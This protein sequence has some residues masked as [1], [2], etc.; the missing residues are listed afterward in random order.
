MGLGIVETPVRGRG[1]VYMY[2]FTR[3]LTAGYGP[4]DLGSCFE[5]FNVGGGVEMA[6]NGDSDAD[7][8]RSG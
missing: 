2:G 1:G 5:S 3:L 8:G 4:R 6:T 7:A